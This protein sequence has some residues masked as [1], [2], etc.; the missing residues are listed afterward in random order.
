LGYA[1]TLRA[2]LQEAGFGRIEITRRSLEIRLFSPERFVQLTVAG[3]AT[4]VPAFI[5]MSPE[6]RSA[7]VD[8]IAGEL[9]PLIR[10]YTDG[11]LRFPM[12]THMAFAA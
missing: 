12:S 11:D 8:A 3:A 4:S 6:P 5:S 2:G 1:G 7:L 10:S 9:E